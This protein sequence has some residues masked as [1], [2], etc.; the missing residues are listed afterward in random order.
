MRCFAIVLLAAGLASSAWAER[1]A[2]TPNTSKTFSEL[3]ARVVERD[4]KTGTILKVRP[5]ADAPADA[6]NLEFA[7][8]AHKDEAN[9]II[10][11]STAGKGG[12]VYERYVLVI[13][14]A[15]REEWDRLKA[16]QKARAERDAKEAALQK[17]LIK[18]LTNG[19]ASVG[20]TEAEVTAALGKPKSKSYAQAAGGFALDYGAYTLTFRQGRLEH[21]WERK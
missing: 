9:V 21:A 6:G 7:M 12:E 11:L 1:L 18:R 8:R 20:M 4:E 10:E 14:K 3:L 2:P 15:I 17:E 5:R 16:Q 13:D 19:K